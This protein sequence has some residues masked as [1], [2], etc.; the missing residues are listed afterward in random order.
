MSSQ[1][2]DAIIA[3][4]TIPSLYRDM[5]ASRS[6]DVAVRW[7]PPGSDTATASMTWA[8]YADQA[9]RVAAGLEALGVRPGT[10]SC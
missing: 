7:R 2:I 4:R 3:G 1:D 5:V 9:C 8:E 6:G 10:G